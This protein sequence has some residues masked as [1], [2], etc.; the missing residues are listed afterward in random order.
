MDARTRRVGENEAL[1][2]EIN[3]RLEGLNEAF[4]TMTDKI[5]FVCECAEVSCIDRF[6][7]TAGEY[8]Q[9]RGD[10]TTFAVKPGHEAADMEEVVADRKTYVV[11][12][13]KPGTPAA[14]AAAND[15]RS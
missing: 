5:E 7:M 1:F 9:L 12:R 15:P 14:L 2:R 3:E 6:P 10:P 4:S 8:E 11:I 13:K